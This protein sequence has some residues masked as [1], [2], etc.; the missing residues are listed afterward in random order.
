MVIII[1]INVCCYG[2]GRWFTWTGISWTHSLTPLLSL[3]SQSHWCVAST[4]HTHT[5]RHT[6]THTQRHIHTHAHTHT[7][8]H[9]VY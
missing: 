6:H 8:R 2:D 9:M 4:V 5:D 7:D 3:L 1:I